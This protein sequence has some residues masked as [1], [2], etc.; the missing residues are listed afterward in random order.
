MLLLAT[1]LPVS[2]LHTNLDLSLMV[3]LIECVRSLRRRDRRHLHHVYREHR[4]LDDVRRMG[5]RRLT[6]AQ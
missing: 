4:H 1:Y 5:H 6:R 3:T 2:I